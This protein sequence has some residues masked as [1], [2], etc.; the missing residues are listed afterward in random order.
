MSRIALLAAV[1]CAAATPAVAQD[2]APLVIAPMAAVT[3][4]T[5]PKNT[6]VLVS[7]NQSV[8][9]KGNTWNEGDTFDLS[10]VNPVMLGDYVVIPKGA[11]AKGRITWLTSKGAFGK[12]GKMEIEIESVEVGGRRFPLAGHY[13]QEGEGNTVATVGTVVLA[14][15]F[16]GFV[17]GKSGLIPQG[18]ELVAHTKDDI[19]VQFSGPPPA[20]KPAGI[21]A[22][23]V[24]AEPAA[25]AAPAA[26]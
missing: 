22:T 25:V 6:E 11:P 2:A 4:A 9:T 17:T 19:P 14:G 20:P 23:P 24:Q 1:A 13:R 18:R 15:V 5:L 7:M 21:V 16:A 8:T 12:S 26:K 10:V 3:T